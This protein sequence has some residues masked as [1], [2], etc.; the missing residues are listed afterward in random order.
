MTSRSDPRAEMVSKWNIQMKFPNR[1]RLDYYYVAA[2]LSI[3]FFIFLFGLFF[4]IFYF[5]LL[6]ELSLSMIIFAF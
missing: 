4:F 3:L 6:M 5:D 2:I 1:T